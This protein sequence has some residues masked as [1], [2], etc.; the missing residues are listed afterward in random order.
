MAVLR[1]EGAEDLLDGSEG[2]DLGVRGGEKAREPRETGRTHAENAVR[3][4]F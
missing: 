1:V 3:G 2:V 4:G